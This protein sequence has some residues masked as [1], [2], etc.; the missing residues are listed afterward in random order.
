MHDQTPSPAENS[1]SSGVHGGASGQT[2]GGAVKTAVIG[3]SGFIGRHFWE[4]YRRTYRDCIGTTFSARNPDLAFFDIRQ[5]EIRPLQLEQDGYRA[6]MIAAAKPHVGYCEQNREAASLVNVG[7]TLELIRQLGRTSLQVIF[8]SSDYVFEGRAGRYAD[9][10]EPR[11]TTEY[12]RQK[13]LVEREL[14]SLTDNYLILRLSKTFGVQKND[15]TL[16][17][18]MAGLLASGQEVQAATDQIFCPT[19]IDDLIRAVLAIQAR[20][21]T[22]IL[23]VC[24]PECWSRYDIARALAEVMQVDASL[25]R[26]VRLQEL[27]GMESRP[28]NTSMVCR[29]LSQETGTAFT[30]LRALLPRIAAHWESPRTA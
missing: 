12:G 17:D 22:G 1:D 5:P 26:P 9:A 3:A 18:E 8:L 25:V 15:R 30:P 14:A 20:N 13:A 11:P 19:F 4:A 28:L 7:G 2:P 29:R 6:V 10:A 24:S 21:L 27:P 23:N 16:L